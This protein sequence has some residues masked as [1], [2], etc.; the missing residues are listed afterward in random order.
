MQA[1]FVE[2]ERNAT[3]RL[4]PTRERNDS[5]EDAAIAAS[6]SGIRILIPVRSQQTRM[7]H[8]RQNSQFE[9]PSGRMRYKLLYP[10]LSSESGRHGLKV[11][12]V[13][14]HAP[15]NHSVCIAHLYH[16]NT[17]VKILI[18]KDLLCLLRVIP[19]DLSSTSLSICCCLVRGSRIYYL[20]Y[21]SGQGLLRASRPH[22]YLLQ[23]NIRDAFPSGSSQQP[24]FFC[25][26]SPAHTIV[27]LSAFA[28]SSEHQ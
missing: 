24:R 6:S 1:S 20:E 23:D 14:W 10:A 7:Y 19:L 26:R 13:E 16:H 22:P 4:C 15:E 12:A 2:W 21:R 25:L 28:F 18:Q 9:L 11:S 3:L 5:A 27:F 17:I 8:S